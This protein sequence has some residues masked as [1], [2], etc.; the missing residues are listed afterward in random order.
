[1]KDDRKENQRL[2]KRALKEADRAARAAAI[3][4]QRVRRNF[5]WYFLRRLDAT[6]GQNPAAEFEIQ[7]LDAHGRAR[8]LLRLSFPTAVPEFAGR[9]VPEAVIAQ[10]HS[11]SPGAGDFFDAQG[12]RLNPFTLTPIGG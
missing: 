3:E 5:E 1:M 10:L 7:Q 4:S 6:E 12:R 9:R 8:A 11:L 2:V